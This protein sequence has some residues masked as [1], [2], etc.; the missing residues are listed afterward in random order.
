MVCTVR[1]T[2]PVTVSKSMS[3]GRLLVQ[4]SSIHSSSVPRYT[5]GRVEGVTVTEKG[6]P[7]GVTELQARRVERSQEPATRDF[8]IGGH[9]LWSEHD[10]L[11]PDFLEER[12][13]GHDGASPD[14]PGLGIQADDRR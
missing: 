6:Q 10:H 12:T 1:K 2:L 4:K 7:H 9:R 14:G 8:P 5:R 13:R 3:E 11:V